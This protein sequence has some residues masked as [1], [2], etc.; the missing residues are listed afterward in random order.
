MYC[1]I[2][3]LSLNAFLYYLENH[4]NCHLCRFQWHFCMYY[5][6]IFEFRK[7]V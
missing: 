3:H 7:V 5:F 1:T 4:E 6:G 2:F